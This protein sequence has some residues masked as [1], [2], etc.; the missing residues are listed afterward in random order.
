MHVI[1]M[2]T[3]LDWVAIKTLTDAAY[4][5]VKLLLHWLFNKRFPVLCA[6]KNMRV[7]FS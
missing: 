5:A 3:D 6:E 7:L 2:S 1:F 4:I